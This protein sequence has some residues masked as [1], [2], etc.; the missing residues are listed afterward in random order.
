MTILFWTFFLLII[1]CYFIYPFIVFL[2]ARLKPNPVQ[3]SSIEPTVSI[4]ISLYNEEDVIAAKI[5]N[6]FKLDYPAEKLEIIIGS[7]GSTDRTH[8]IIR[9]FADARIKLYIN[10]L[11]QGKM[12]TINGL[13]PKAANE[14]ILFT[15]ARQSF[16][17]DAIRQL[18]ANF[19]D[20][21]IGCVSGELMFAKKAGGT[22]QGVNLYWNYEKFI[23]RQE[24]ILHSMLG[25]TG[26][27]YAIRKS[28]F[29]PGPTDIVLDDMYTPFKIIQQGYRAIFEDTAYA[30]D[31]VAGN[32]K[33][34]YRRK[35]RTLFG[36]YQIFSLFP[37]MFNPFKSPI[38]W[39]L[40]SHKFLRVIIP[41]FL[42]AL[43]AINYFLRLDP[44]F[45]LFWFLQITFYLMA[46]IGHLT[47]DYKEG[48]FKFIAKICYVPYVFC[49][50]NIS[51]F[52][53]FCRFIT[54][55]QQTTWDK[56]RGN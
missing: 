14:I 39:Q 46:L 53:G 35:T 27:I 43:F 23:R 31:Q 10:P 47:R 24:S 36:N 1:Y 32:P 21:K 18:V 16:E 11:R 41:F 38:A 42:I 51:A 49:L 8:D 25:A 29:M 17:T 12:A 22:A 52:V 9:Q 3:K 50:L 13:I 54:A 5:E 26:A 48:I 33:E 37:G 55:R 44:V 28:L 6:L 45:D 34:E 56:A 2:L 40:F 19:A 4:V 7:D 15:D 30:Y 20:P